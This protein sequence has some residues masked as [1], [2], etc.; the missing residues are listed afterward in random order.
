[1]IKGVKIKKLDNHKDERGYLME[2]LRSDDPLFLKF[3]QCYLSVCNPKTI[4]G[5]HYHKIQTDNFVVIKGTAR[6][7]LYDIRK[8]SDSKGE[9]NEFIMG[10]DNLLFLQIP[11]MVVHAVQAI[12]KNP[13]YLINLPT[14]LYDY[15]NPDELRIEWNSDDIPYTWERDKDGYGT[16]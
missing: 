3:A 15:K 10:E 9:I 1:M 13:S 11:P 6:V 14:E 5:W 12:G 7:V 16:I 8:N 2:I 4:K